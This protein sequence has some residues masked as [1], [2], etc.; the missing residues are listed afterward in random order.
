MPLKVD[1]KDIQENTK[2]ADKMEKAMD[3]AL[4]TKAAVMAS[5]TPKLKQLEKVER[6]L[7]D[8]VK[9]AKDRVKYHQALKKEVEEGLAGKLK[10]GWEHDADRRVKDFI[11]VVEKEDTPKFERLLKEYEEDVDAIKDGLK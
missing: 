6:Q 8:I 3:E 4:R 11:G 1:P 9:T 5:I 10:P 2:E 7:Q